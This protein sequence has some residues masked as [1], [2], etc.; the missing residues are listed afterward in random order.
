MKT[1]L[2]L[3]I[4]CCYFGTATAQVGDNYFISSPSSVPVQ[5][6]LLDFRIYHLFGD[7]AGNN[8]GISTFYG[9]DNVRDIKFSFDYG[10]T[11]NISI[12]IARTKGAYSRRQNFVLNSKYT[13]LEINKLG[14]N[15]KGF[16]GGAIYFDATATTMEAALDSTSELSFPK[17]TS[18]LSY[19]TVAVL[20]YNNERWDFML[21]GL[22]NHRNY[23]ANTD[24]NGA[25]A[26]IIGAKYAVTNVFRFGVDALLPTNETKPG[27]TLDFEFDTGGH[28]FQ[29]YLSQYSA[30]SPDQNL[31]YG[32]ENINDG[33]FRFGFMISR[34][35]KL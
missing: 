33:A 1:K 35:F 27:I 20:Q 21:S 25:F 13:F 8:G 31:L 17:F 24:D 5:K 15:D 2:F 16:L 4:A 12:G 11:S 28:V 14:K 32:F 23:V 19:N 9:F 10:L 26:A 30:V 6:G 22:Y 18:R 3:L 29:L 7:I 34:P